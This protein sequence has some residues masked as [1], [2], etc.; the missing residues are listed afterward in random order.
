[1]RQRTALLRSQVEEPRRISIVLRHACALL[2]AIAESESRIGGGPVGHVSGASF[3]SRFRSRRVKKQEELTE[4]TG[5]VRIRALSAAM[6]SAGPNDV[7]RIRAALI[8]SISDRRSPNR[9]SPPAETPAKLRDT[10]L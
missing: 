1:M 3:V 5:N 6:S 7:T 2:Q 9:T 10:C 8:S 4:W